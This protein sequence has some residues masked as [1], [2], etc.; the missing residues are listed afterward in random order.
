[1][2]KKTNAVKKFFMKHLWRF[3]QSQ[4]FVS[5]LLWSLALSGIFYERSGWYFEQYFGLSANPD[6]QV[7][8]KMAIL[9][10]MVIM[11]VVFF[12]F[13]YDTIFRLW[14]Q[15]NIV[16]ME[17]NVFGQYKFNVK[18]IITMRMLYIP[19]LKSVNTGEYD[20]EIAF[21]E[22]WID[23]LLNDDAIA[24]MFYDHILE[25]IES[26]A[27]HWKAPTMEKLLAASRE[28]LKGKPNEE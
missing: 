15:Q 9:M 19:L 27:L 26:D 18:E 11:M 8:T 5:I 12:G 28:Q 25:W 3:Q 17:R 7:I 23:K 24:Q 6:E 20:R 13:M 10:A 21:M 22:R 4:A 1:M 14:E 16:G 2:M